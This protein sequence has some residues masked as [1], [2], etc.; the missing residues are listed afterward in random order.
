[1]ITSTDDKAEI[2][3]REKYILLGFLIGFMFF[4]LSLTANAI[5]DYLHNHSKWT[6]IGIFGLTAELILWVLLI[7][8]GISSKS[9]SK[10]GFTIGLKYDD[11]KYWSRLFQGKKDRGDSIES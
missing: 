1:M 4:I 8:Y 11:S 3:V 10:K 9:K 6:L 5:S 2:R 7:R